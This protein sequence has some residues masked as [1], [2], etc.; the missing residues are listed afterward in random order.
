VNSNLVKFWKKPLGMTKTRNF[1]NSKFNLKQASN[2]FVS[3]YKGINM[4]DCF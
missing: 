2:V 4:W 1:L 3:V